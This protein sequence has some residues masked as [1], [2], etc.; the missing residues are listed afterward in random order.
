[1]PDALS[2]QQGRKSG[3]DVDWPTL[4]GVT[5]ATMTNLD[6][7]RVP[8][9]DLST[10]IDAL[11]PELSAA[12]TNVLRSGRFVLGPEVESFE[13]EVATYLG[14]KHAVGLNSGT[15]A[16][17][18]GLRALGVEAGDEVITTS[19]SFFATAEAI[20]TVGAVP[21][22]VDVDEESFNLDSR[23]LEAAIGPRTKAV[24]PVHLFGRP[25]AM[26][27]VM[28]VARRHGLKVL[29]DCAQSFGA[30]YGLGNAAGN[31]SART[32]G[33][34]P[35]LDGTMT[36]SFGDAGAFSF[37]PTK[38]L[39]AYGDGGLLVS[40]DDEV[41]RLARMLRN[42]GASPE[43]RYENEMPGYNSRLD[44]FQAAV[45]RV[46]LPHVEEWNQSRREV[47]MSY[48]ERLAGTPGLVL[49]ADAPGHVYHQFT[50]RV[51]AD[52]R[53]DT[54]AGLDRA[55]IASSIFYPKPLHLMLGDGSTRLPVSERL[56]TEV[57]SLPI[58][59]GVT[60]DAVER[61]CSAL[62]RRSM[63]DSS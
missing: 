4:G 48:R 57:L 54:I 16:L 52:R 63:S 11:W 6:T 62:L 7:T 29:E 33:S 30:R 44:E 53:A 46:K 1:M 40:N 59:P 23:L 19:F 15:D 31:V 37:Y 61:V 20:V 45:L 18:I 2:T 36:G 49:P 28:E 60:S 43:R 14:V 32:D 5:G 27:A 58:S 12:L 25:A 51:Q 21:V 26:D 8:M 3:S 17:V 42:H 9:L 55:G 38:N 13:R 35:A 24:I 22:Y 39:G 50:V 47:A 34:R 41:A 56:S 10:E